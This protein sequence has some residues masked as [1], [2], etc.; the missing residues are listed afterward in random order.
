MNHFYVVLYCLVMATEQ[1]ERHILLTFNINLIVWTF[2]S[3]S[4]NARTAL[5]GSVSITLF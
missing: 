2:M 1:T 4:S 5:H 3:L